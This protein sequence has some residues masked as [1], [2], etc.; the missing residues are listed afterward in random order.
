MDIFIR[1]QPYTG[2]VRGVILDWA[3]TAVDYGCMGPAAVFVEVFKRFGVDVTVEEA[4]RFMGREKKDHIRVMC[5][6]PDIAE[7]WRRVHGAAPAD[8]DV[9]AIYQQTE[10]MMIAALGKHAEL[11]PGLLDTVA[12]LR[13]RQ[14]KI[15]SCT[16]YTAPMME[17]LVSAARDQ[18]YAPEAVICSSDVPAGRPYPWMSYLNAV[19]LQVYPLEAMVKIGDTVADIAEG[20]N[21]GM[22]T[23]GLTRSGNELG[24]TREQTEALDPGDLAR[25]LEAIRLRYEK[26]GAHYVAAG[27]WDVMPIVDAIEERL[28]RGERP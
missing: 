16:G 13:G 24:L 9:E 18:G 12:A 20:L 10:P 21:A 2:S 19:R 25:R 1:K 3:G 26:A 11:I 7:R 8:R 22:W 4:R 6:L 28:A 14:I 5:R 17:V 15:G 27:I 23:V